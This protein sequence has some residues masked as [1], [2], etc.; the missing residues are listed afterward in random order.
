MSPLE[1]AST[2]LV[3]AIT[4]PGV[5]LV[6][7]VLAMLFSHRPDERRVHQM[8]AFGMS[9]SLVLATLLLAALSAGVVPPFVVDLGT[10][11]AVRGYHFDLALSADVTGVLYLWLDILLCGVVGA[12]SAPYLHQDE[13]YHRFYLLL[14]AFSLGLAFVATGAGLDVVFAGWEVLGLTSALLIAF[15]YRR[16]APV[17]NGLRAY[18]VYR[19]TDVGLLLSLVMLHHFVGSAE[20]TRLDELSTVEASL[21]GALI[22]FGAMGKGAIVPF[23]PWLPRAMEGPTPSS[24]VFYGALSIHA[25]PFLLIRTATLFD[26]APW[27]QTVVVGLGS[28]TAVHASMV[29]R[30]Q[31]DIKC[32]LGY[33]SVAQV[34]VI[35]VWIGLG[36]QSLAMAHIVGHA[37]LRTWQ[38]LRAPSLLHDRHRL[39]QHL[40]THIRATGRFW[41]GITPRSLRR[42]LY[43]LALERWYLD[44]LWDGLVSRLVGVLRALDSLDRRWASWLREEYPAQDHDLHVEP[45]EVKA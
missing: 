30:V 7:L 14:L 16:R 10:L 43:R 41:N 18:A 34:G 32:S 27:L 35:W 9:G 8:M 44:D 26:Q 33:A 36:F 24:A 11:L 6:V 19:I 21:I 31:T 1:A 39:V 15:F 2:A 25:S 40:G 4:L 42:W 5:A 45:F 29:G 37:I 28:V 20:L 12:F 22:I 3:S 38:L 17:E 13:G 23:T